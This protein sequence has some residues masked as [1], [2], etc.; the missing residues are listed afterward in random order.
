MRLPRYLV[1]EW[2]LSRLSEEK[3]GEMYERIG[4]LIYQAVL[5]RAL[6]ILSETQQTEFDLLLEEEAVTPNE[7]LAFLASK[8][9]SFDTILAEERDKIREEILLPPTNPNSPKYHSCFISYSVSD[10]DFADRL[11]DDLVRQ[12]IK[13]WFAPHDLVG[14]R[15]LLDQI[16]NALHSHDRVLLILSEDSMR[17]E[18]VKT[19]IAKA[20]KRE[21]AERKG[22]GVGQIL[23]PVGLAPFHVIGDWECFDADIGKD[24]AR[25][26]REYFIPDFHEWH[27]PSIYALAFNYVLAGLRES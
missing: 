20:R 9:E 22:G 2:G 19:E 17:S 4:K 16:H 1:K 10:Q 18:W 13:S 12:G 27:N 3:Q 5:V 26:I 15:K 25:E 8:I 6:D 7:I 14:G 24:S 21:I 11:F 23:C